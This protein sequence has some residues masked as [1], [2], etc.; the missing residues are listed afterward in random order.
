MTNKA[1]E[2]ILRWFKDLSTADKQHHGRQALDRALKTYQKTL[3][4]LTDDDWKDLTEWRGVTEKNT[5]FEQISSG[6]LLP[7]LVVTR[8]FNDEVSDVQ[9]K[10]HN[11]DMTQPQQL[12]ANA[13]GVELDFANCCHPIYGD[14]IVGH[15]SRHG[16]VVHRHKCFSLDD[17]RKDNP[18]QVIQL[19]WRSDNAVKQGETDE[20]DIKNSG[21]I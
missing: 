1:R 2:E 6:T 5:L 10:A 12:I 14:P 21:K 4:D 18:Y 3:D 15:L 17:I 9:A 20:H 13:S 19:R 7:Q 11:E 16:L 8:L